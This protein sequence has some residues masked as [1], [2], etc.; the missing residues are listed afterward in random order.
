MSHVHVLTPFKWDCLPHICPEDKEKE[1]RT[2]PVSYTQNLILHVDY[3]NHEN[4]EICMA[5]LDFNFLA[6]LSN[7]FISFLSSCFKFSSA[8]QLSEL[9]LVLLP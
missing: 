2:F 9:V 7:H 1:S 6:Y 5:R 4:K 8:L 3:I